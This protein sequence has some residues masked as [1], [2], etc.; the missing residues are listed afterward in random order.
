MN[1]YRIFDIRNGL[2][3]HPDIIVEAKSPQ[4]A[5]ERLYNNVKRD[6]TGS[7]DI[8]VN[9]TRGSFVYNGDRNDTNI[10]WC[11]DGEVKVCIEHFIKQAKKEF[12]EHYFNLQIDRARLKTLNDIKAIICCATEQEREDGCQYIGSNNF[13]DM[14][15]ELDEYEEKLEVKE[16]L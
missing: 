7:G 16:Y 1:K 10:V 9:G 3:T 12:D 4:K 6:F 5:V 11:D 8:V 15:N 14:W 2:G 13:E